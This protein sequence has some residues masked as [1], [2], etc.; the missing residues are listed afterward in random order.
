MVVPDN[1]KNGVTH[2]SFYEPDLNPSYVD[3][4]RHLGTAH[5]L[6]GVQAAGFDGGETQSSVPEMASHYID[7]MR[8]EHVENGARLTVVLK[9]RFTGVE[10]DLLGR[11][12]AF[13]FHPDDRHGGVF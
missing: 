5:P 9:R 10:L 11:P 2:P 7:A 6:I 4:A 12:A 1:L 13:E 3:L 8:E